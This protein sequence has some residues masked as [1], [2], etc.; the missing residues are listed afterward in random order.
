MF[1]QDSFGRTA[2]ATAVAADAPVSLL[3]S[4]VELDKEDTTGRWMIVEVG[5]N[6]DDSPLELAAMHRTDAA[7]IE[8]L[9]REYP[10]CSN[11]ALACALSHNKKSNAVVSLLRK[12]VTAFERG[13]ISALIELCGESRRVVG[14]ERGGGAV[15]CAPRCH[16]GHLS[17]L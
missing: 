12:C 15:P 10:S 16:V 9:V 6:E 1:S 17:G 14:A 7:A 8:L 2:F 11:N 3:H 4:M 13:N 5:D